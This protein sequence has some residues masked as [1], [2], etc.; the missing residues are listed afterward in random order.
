MPSSQ[1]R[2]GLS[3]RALVFGDT[4]PWCLVC[5]SR[6]FG[7]RSIPCKD[8][9]YA[10]RQSRNL[11]SLLEWINPA[12]AYLNW[13]RKVSFSIHAPLCFRHFWRGLLGEFLVIGALVLALLGILVLWRRGQLPSGPSLAGAWLKMALIG[14]V[15]GGSWLV[16]RLGRPRSI[17]PCDVKR[18]SEHQ[19]IL[20]YPEGLPTPVREGRPKSA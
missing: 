1:V 3:G 10:M 14:I 4:P 18:E 19:V 11:N 9:D 13:R 7:R 6:P 5:G 16:S 2:L 12:L 17:L 20:I 15:V 8:A